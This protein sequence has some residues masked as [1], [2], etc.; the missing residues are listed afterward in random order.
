M[1]GHLLCCHC[2][3]L[4]LLPLLTLLVCPL[5]TSP[6]FALGFFYS[7]LV[8]GEV[9]GIIPECTSRSVLTN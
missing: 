6:G 4:R 9:W 2:R 8:E 1:P 5:G 3:Y 7:I